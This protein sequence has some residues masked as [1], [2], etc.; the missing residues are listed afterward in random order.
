MTPRSFWHPR[1]WPG[2]LGVGLLRVLV[3]LPYPIQ[4]ALGRTL[5]R[6]IE[7]FAHARRHVVEKNLATCFPEQTEAQR[8]TL[9]HSHFE[10][11]GISV[12]ETAMGWFGSRARLAKLTAIE[13]AEHLSNALAKGR[14][15]ILYTGHFTTLEVAGPALGAL[16]PALTA[17]YRPHRSAFMD[18]LFRSGRLKSAAEVIPKDS[19]RPMLR[20]L[21]KNQALW[22]APDQS[23]RRKQSALV[24]FFGEPAMTNIATPQLAKISGA[25]VVPFFP[26]R[27]PGSAGYR[28]TFGAPVTPFPTD[29]AEADTRLLVAILESHIRRCPDQYYWVHRKFKER[30]APLPDIYATQ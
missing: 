7:R 10:S 15:V 23:Y 20:S 4:L 25:E 21:K 9:L 28:L 29:D 6:V 18:H 22:Y 26:E 17:V 30:P 3:L 14:G 2:W 11:L 27:L 13:G 1:F 24:P 5:G 12:F 16:C 8:E 19:V